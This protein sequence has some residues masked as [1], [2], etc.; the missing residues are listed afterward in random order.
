VQGIAALL[1]QNGGHDP[2]DDIE[3][4]RLQLDRHHR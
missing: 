2:A 3:S 4:N 1:D